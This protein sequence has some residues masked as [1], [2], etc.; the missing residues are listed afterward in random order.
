MFP[1][2]LWDRCLDFLH[3]DPA[4]LRACA[5]VCRDWLPACTH[6]IFSTLAV[7]QDGEDLPSSAPALSFGRLCALIETNPALV[8]HVRT[9]RTH[10]CTNG[11]TSVVLGVLGGP[12]SRIRSLALDTQPDVFC[13]SP[14]DS[15]L[16]D[17]F[18]H[19]RSLS[20]QN[21][22]FDSL[23][24]LAAQLHP[25]RSLKRLDLRHVLLSNTYPPQEPFPAP[26][27]EDCEVSLAVNNW[28]METSLSI[29][30]PWLSAFSP[31]L[32][33]VSLDLVGLRISDEGEPGRELDALAAL[34]DIHNASLKTLNLG[35]RDRGGEH[36]RVVLAELALCSALE[37]LAITAS[38][39]CPVEQ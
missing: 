9:L 36:A 4:A 10:Q 7:F 11:L 15:C 3:D 17:K 38:V 39:P 5:V 35:L 23:G 19:L 18:P 28:A 27:F 21:V 31:Q 6:H 30:W 14:F 13:E 26:A 24:A 34:L 25:L 2:E 33:V 37:H 20:L 22:L 32:R 1:P 8:G 16:P 12:N 29:F